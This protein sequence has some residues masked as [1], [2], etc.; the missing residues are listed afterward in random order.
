MKVFAEDGDLSQTI[1]DILSGVDL[2]AADGAFGFEKL[3]YDEL[4]KFAEGGEI[5]FE[6][7]KSVF[8]KTL[9]NITGDVTKKTASL[10]VFVVAAIIIE[11][12]KIRKTPRR[13]RR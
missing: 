9:K 5:T 10:L 11:I 3:S 1:K 2:N 13:Q 7:L 12:I 4:L 6:D 8:K